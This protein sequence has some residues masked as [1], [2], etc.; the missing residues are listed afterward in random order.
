M[1][2]KK[3][4]QRDELLERAMGLFREHGFA[5]TSTEMLVAH[6]GVNR[7]TMY[8]E[9]GSKQLLFSLALDRY[10]QSVI[11]QSVG[12]LEAGDAGLAD[13]AALFQFYA[14]AVEGQGYGRGC[15]LCNTAVEL[16]PADPTGEGQVGRYFE[17]LSRAFLSP[18]QNAQH[19][20][21]V[22][23][24]VDVTAAADFLTAAA[25]GIFV[26]LRAQAPRAQVVN[27]ARMAV[28][29]VG[30]LGVGGERHRERSIVQD[31]RKMKGGEKR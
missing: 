4:Y 25:L 10:D 22:R 31:P 30:A 18:L 9:F 12:R 20:G 27:G 2:R 21:Q 11:A 3:T 23:P 14:S 8:R 28:S 7:N 17:R 6:L 5:G 29:F 16:G 15:L 19:M 26:M 24:D 13:V 1:G